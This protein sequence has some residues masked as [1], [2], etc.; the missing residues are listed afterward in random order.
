MAGILKIRDKDGNFVSVPA[1]VGPKGDNGDTPY[2]GS[3]NHWWIGDVDTGV[4]AKGEDGKTPQK[5]VDYF[6]GDYQIEIYSVDH[7]TFH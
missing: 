5:G 7:V 3:N 4:I 2:I 1:I 6:D